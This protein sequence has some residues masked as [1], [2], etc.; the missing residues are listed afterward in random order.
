MRAARLSAARLS[1]AGALA[2]L[3]GCHHQT[4]GEDQRTAE[5][6]VLPGS[7]S[8]AMLPYD[9]VRSQPPLLP[10]AERATKGAGDA[11]SSAATDAAS[12]ID[13]APP[14]PADSAGGAGATN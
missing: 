13:A 5:G 1:I 6:K 10:R 11:A 2:L 12:P 9:S 7:I 3:C 4:K 14:P 8:D